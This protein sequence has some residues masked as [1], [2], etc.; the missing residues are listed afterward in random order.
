MKLGICRKAVL[1]ISMLLCIG[2]VLATDNV[3]IC[4]KIDSIVKNQLPEGT[5]AS[6]MVYD[7]TNDTDRKSVV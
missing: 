3:E 7:L 1:T 2:S 5:D 6:I 4:D